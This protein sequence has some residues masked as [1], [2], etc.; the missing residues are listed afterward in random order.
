MLT[1]KQQTQ[2]ETYSRLY[3]DSLATLRDYQLDALNDRL[4][5]QS[6]NLLI[7]LPTGTGKSII[8]KTELL[9]NLSQGLKTLVLAPS[10]EL[11]WNI[12]N[13]LPEYMTYAYA[14]VTP[15]P[16]KRILVTT[17]QS[18]LKWSKVFRPDR[19]IIDECHH[20]SKDS[21]LD[22]ILRRHKIPVTGYTATPNRLDGHGLH[23]WFNR[24]HT[25][26]QIAWYIDQGYLANYTLY[27]QNLLGRFT[28]STDNLKAQEKTMSVR[29]DEVFRHWQTYAN[30]QKTIV[31]CPTIEYANQLSKYFAVNGVPNSVISSSTPN[32]DRR[33]R[34][35]AF[36][37][38]KVKILFNVQIFT[39]GVDV[40]DCGCVMLVRFTYSLPLYL[41]MIGRVL[42]PKQDGSKAIILDL[43]SNVHY[44]GEPKNPFF[45]DLNDREKQPKNNTATNYKKCFDCDTIL[46][47]R[48]LVKEPIKVCCLNC[49]SE[50]FFEPPKK[51]EKTAF[52]SLLEGY[53]VEL[54]RIENTDLTN[55]ARLYNQ[56][57]K[58]K[59][60]DISALIQAVF[61]SNLDVELKQKILL[62][63]GVSQKT[64]DIYF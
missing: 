7:Q 5:N 17:Y 51:R 16:T 31:F 3:K 12:A 53:T 4:K 38:N 24:I 50:N 8:I 46:F 32:A 58:G 18:A 48:R 23:P 37:Q 30:N 19:I 59:K 11:V 63:V 10:T 22:A 47:N 39:E 29:F 2:L 42:R 14:G 6:D 56:H 62:D 44:H 61:N 40:P 27:A 1:A 41:Q 28:E 9:H 60:I 26:H 49:G 43:V 21:Q 33:K 55:I 36:K 13:Y 45:W 54:V 35:E 15:N 20:V 25:G 34:F 52:D 57:K 64:L